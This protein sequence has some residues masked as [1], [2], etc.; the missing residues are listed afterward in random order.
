VSYQ[1][2]VVDDERGIRELVRDA[3]AVAGFTVTGAADGLEALTLLRK[4]KWDLCILDINLPTVDGFSL[5]E[6]LR[7]KDSQTPVLLLSA[8]GENADVTHGLK[9]GADDYVRK[10]FG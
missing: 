9:I 2:L 7:E 8:R 4:Q 6:K 5:L 10:P 3:L 1:V